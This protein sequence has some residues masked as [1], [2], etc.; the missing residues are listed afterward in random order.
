M[1]RYGF[2]PV[3]VLMWLVRFLLS[4]KK[5]VTN[6][7][8]AG[9]FTGM[10]CHM[11]LKITIQWIRF[12]TLASCNGFSP[13]CV[14]VWSERLQFWAKALS[15]WRHLK[16]LSPVCVFE[17]CISELAC[18]KAF[19]HWEHWYGFSLVCVLR[20]Y[21]RQT[22]VEN[23]FPQCLQHYIHVVISSEGS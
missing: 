18:E 13:V 19:S 3:C 4:E 17:C 10:Y 2:S 12:A 6:T 22:I 8:L 7:T 11:V 1:H 15:Q 14:L 16:G 23:F 5:I 21:V 20:R 9:F